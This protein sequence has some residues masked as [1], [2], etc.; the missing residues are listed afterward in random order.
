MQIPLFIIFKINQNSGNPINLGLGGFPKIMYFSLEFLCVFIG[1]Y[2]SSKLIPL[3][4]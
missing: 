1:D 2:Y 3:P 4:K